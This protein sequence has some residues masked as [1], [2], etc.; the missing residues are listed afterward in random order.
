MIKGSGNARRARQQHMQQRQQRQQQQQQ[1]PQQH[2]QQQHNQQQMNMPQINKPQSVEDLK[3][4]LELYG[5]AL[6]NE[7]KAFINELVC[8]LEGGA[9]RSQLLELAARMQA[10]ANRQ[11]KPDK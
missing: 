11:S 7:N 1:S 10:A 4:L 2:N 3:R 9:D 5:G 6:S 8:G